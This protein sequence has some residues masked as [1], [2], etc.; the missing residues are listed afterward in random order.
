MKYRNSRRPL[1]LTASV[2]L[3]TMLQSCVDGSKVGNLSVQI[4]TECEKLRAKKTFP[5]ISESGDY[6]DLSIDALAALKT[7]YRTGDRYAACVLRVVNNYAKGGV[8]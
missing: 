2:L 8:P 7:A 1:I 6:R 4:T 5:Q 3:A